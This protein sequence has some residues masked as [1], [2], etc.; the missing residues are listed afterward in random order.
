MKRTW[1]ERVQNLWRF[2]ACG[3]IAPFFLLYLFLAYPYY[4]WQQCK[5]KLMRR[6]LYNQELM[7][8][9]FT[10]KL[11]AWLGFLWICWEARNH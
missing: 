9:E 11:A 10:G 2:L 7:L 8:W 3:V 5:R 6:V 1:K 4:C